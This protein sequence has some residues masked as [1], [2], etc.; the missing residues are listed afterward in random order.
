MTPER[1][2]DGIA[3]NAAMA[4]KV[5]TM[6]GCSRATEILED[7]LSRAG[8]MPAILIGIDPDSRVRL[9]AIPGLSP[10]DCL[11]LIEVIR[12]EL[13]EHVAAREGGG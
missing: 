2:A 5:D 9:V 10:G 8:S 12:G 7:R 3:E 4:D 1:I 11:K 6:V 13:A